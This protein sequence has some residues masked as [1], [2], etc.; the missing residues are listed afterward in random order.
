MSWR[1]T[2]NDQAGQ[3]GVRAI[4]IAE[5]GGSIPASTTLKATGKTELRDST[6]QVVRLGAGGEFTLV[7][8][9]LGL[10]P[11]CYGE[12]VLLGKRGH[13]KYRT[14]CWGGGLNE[15]VD[16][17]VRP[18]P[19]GN[20]DDYYVYRGSIAITEYDTSGRAYGICFVNEGERL[21]LA[22]DLGKTGRDR[23]SVVSSSAL[24]D[25]DYNYFVGTYAD[26]RNWR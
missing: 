25:A 17:M 15:I 7:D 16:L 22:Y 6:G 23:Y 14:S 9:P 20:A 11:E 26:P 4:G 13:I 18:N 8:S 24:T 3:A 19:G 10:C 5:A 12:V 21:T 2:Y 1:L